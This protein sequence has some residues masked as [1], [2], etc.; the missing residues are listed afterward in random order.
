M[1]SFRRFKEKIADGSL[2]EFVGELRWLWRYVKRYHIIIMIHMLLGVLGILMGLGS[3][4]ASKYL[5]DAVTGYNTGTIG[6]AAATMAGMMLG[7]IAVRSLTM[8]IGAVLNIKVQNEIQANL[9]SKILSADWESMEQYSNGDL[10]NRLN[11]DANTVSGGVTGFIPSLVSGM[12]QFIGSFAII[13]YYDPTMSAIA[14]L[15]VPVSVVCSRMLVRRMRSHNREM[16]EI[17]SEMMSFQEDSFQNLT[18]IKA[19]GITDLFDLRMHQVQE[20]YTGAYMD[21]NRFAVRTSV[22]VSLLGMVVTAGC[23]GWGVFRLWSG[24]ITYGSMTMFI[25]LASTLSSSF[26]NLVG[27]VPSMVS[28]STSAGRLMSAIAWQEESFETDVQFQE[29]D[30]YVLSL[31]H[32]SFNYHNGET[33]LNDVNFVARPGDLVALNGPSGEGK[34][35]MLRILL[36]LVRPSQGTSELI[37]S[38]GQ[39][40][41]I[42]AATRTAF[43]YVPQGNSM[44]SGTVAENLRMTRPEATDEEL[45]EV[46][47]VA[48]A[49][50]FVQELPGGLYH[51]LGGRSRSLSEGQAQRLAVAR[52]LLRRAPILLLDEATSALDEDT[53]ARMLDNLMNSGLVHTCILVTH[54][55]GTRRICTR[56]YRLSGGELIEEKGCAV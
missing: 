49:D 17:Y 9:Y 28:I 24:M 6:V 47:R 44:F 22:F 21:Y 30:S 50:Q 48:C 5:L 40:F 7:N 4:V 39:R 51:Q 25:Q 26:S 38:S 29:E 31:S 23:F 54:R 1:S 35:T 52:A 12:V 46:L 14:L 19:F 11:S 53:E 33:V 55:P 15:S 45:W 27:M 42:S 2:K 43:G 18:S 32:V 34:T 10:L 13:T 56:S 16:K 37:G 41:S 36:G 8:R 3:S 20:K